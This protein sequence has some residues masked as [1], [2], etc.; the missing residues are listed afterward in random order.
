MLLNNSKAAVT[1]NALVL[2]E[3]SPL[4]NQRNLYPNGLVTF[5]L[6]FTVAH[7]QVNPGWTSGVSLYMALDM[8]MD[9]EG[10][11]LKLSLIGVT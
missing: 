11:E 5:S 3:H 1:P 2:F 10:S 6:E 4:K 8:Y 7:G 9:T